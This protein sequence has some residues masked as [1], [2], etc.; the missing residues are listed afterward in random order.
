MLDLNGR[1]VFQLFRFDELGAPILFA[2]LLRG[3]ADMDHALIRSVSTY[4][5]HALA[6]PQVK[7][8][9]PLRQ[10]DAAAFRKTSV[11]G[12]RG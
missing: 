8:S 10:S 1:R 11:I 3:I 12:V 7:R 2:P 6:T 5:V 4:E 9:L